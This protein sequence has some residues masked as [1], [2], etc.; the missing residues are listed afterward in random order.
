MSDSPMV[1]GTASSQHEERDDSEHVPAPSST[2]ETSPST[3]FP[4]PSDLH[5]NS[6]PA[7]VQPIDSATREESARS[8]ATLDANVDSSGTSPD[9]TDRLKLYEDYVEARAELVLQVVMEC[10]EKGVVLDYEYHKGSDKDGNVLRDHEYPAKVN[11]F[12]EHEKWVVKCL[13]WGGCDEDDEGNA[14]WTEDDMF[15]FFQIRHVCF[16]HVVQAG[17]CKHL[18]EVACRLLSKWY[19]CVVLADKARVNTIEGSSSPI[20]AQPVDLATSQKAAERR[21]DPDMW[22]DIKGVAHHID[23]LEDLIS[24]MNGRVSEVVGECIDK[25]VVFD[26]NYHKGSDQHGGIVLRDPEYPDTVNAFAELKKWKQKL[27]QTRFRGNDDEGN[28]LWTKEDL[29]RWI[30]VLRACEHYVV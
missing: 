14:V 2:Q 21:A 5:D 24:S 29:W 10:V 28:T 23:D 18:G 1:H 8:E 16:D 27:R 22:V 4:A 25:G 13:Y 9:Y 6:T 3:S 7:Q 30:Q 19:S 15:R 12:A 20:R 17:L 11:A 26:Y